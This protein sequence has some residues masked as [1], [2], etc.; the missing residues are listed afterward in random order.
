MIAIA[1]S[2]SSIASNNIAKKIKEI[3]IPSWAKMYEFDEDEIDLPLDTVSEEQIIVLSKHKSA[4]GTKSFTTHS[5]GNFDKAEYGGKEKTL[6][7][8]MPLIQTNL[9]RG[10]ATNNNSD[11]LVC[12]EVTHH[13]PFTNKS[14]CFIELGSSEDEWKQEASAEII[15]NVVT[16]NTNKENNDVIAI[17]IGGGHYAPDFT[18]LAIRK[19]YSFGHICPMYMLEKLDSN[20]LTQMI[21]KTG[22]TEII[23]DWKGLKNHKEKVIALC[24]ESGLPFERVQRLLKN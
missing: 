11:H 23:I 10:L 9:L 1:Y 2:N 8:S 13:G 7:N 5:L 14:V 20:L 6:V 3:G 16:K 18:K 24:E 15:A 12:F 4:A 17:G 22:A 19:N 21:E